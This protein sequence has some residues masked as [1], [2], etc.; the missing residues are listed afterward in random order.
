MRRR[1]LFYFSKLDPF[2]E[3]KLYDTQ[4]IEIVEIIKEELF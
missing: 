2:F 3:L 1:I 4:I